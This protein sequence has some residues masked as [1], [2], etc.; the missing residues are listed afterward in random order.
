MNDTPLREVADS[1]SVDVAVGTPLVTN[2]DNI[3]GGVATLALAAL[4]ADAGN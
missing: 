4:V 3:M 2:T 1:G